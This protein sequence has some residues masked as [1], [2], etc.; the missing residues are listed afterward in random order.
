M[1]T[2]H[3]QRLN[4]RYVAEAI[5]KFHIPNQ[6]HIRIWKNL[7]DEECSNPGLRKLKIKEITEFV[8]NRLS[9]IH[10]TKD[11]IPD[12]VTW[13]A[14]GVASWIAS[15]FGSIN[16]VEVLNRFDEGVVFYPEWP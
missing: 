10:P 11:F 9:A 2:G 3:Q 14:Y 16:A 12:S 4:S 5:F 1:V 13:D 6:W 7:S 15:F 8:S